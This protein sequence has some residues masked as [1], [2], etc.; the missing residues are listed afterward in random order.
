MATRFKLAAL[1]AIP[2]IIGTLAYAHQGRAHHGPPDA[3]HA[4]MHLDHM[5]KMLGK[6]GAT[7]AQKSRID[8]ILREAFANMTA[9]KD[10]H[11]AAFGKFHE[12]LFAPGVDREKIEALR[13]QQV[14]AL[15]D[16]SRDIVTAFTDAAEVLD[17]EQRAA[18]AREIRNHHGG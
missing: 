17:P 1:I 14:R 8:G 4:E 13:A 10:G 6:I 15:D 9:A 7:E 11:H 2:L 18:L 12:L 16:A 5:A 3:H